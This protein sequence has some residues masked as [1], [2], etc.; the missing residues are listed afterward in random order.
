MDIVAIL[1]LLIGFATIVLAMILKEVPFSAFNNPAAFVVIF[2]GTIASV[3][4]ATPA[5]EIKNIG[6][7][8][9]VVFGKTRF[10]KKTDAAKS[11]VEYS[12]IARKEGLLALE[13]HADAE[14]DLFMK[15]GLQLLMDGTE[16]EKIEEALS[17]DIAAMQQRHAG[18]AQIMS[19]AGS[20]APTLGVL[21]AV[22]GLIAALGDLSD[23][24]RLSHAISAAF[25]ATVL[26]IFTGYVMWNPMANR[27]KRKTQLEV[28]VKNMIMD[29][30][31]GISKGTAPQMLE[32]NLYAYLTVKERKAMGSNAKE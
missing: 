31:C 28:Q 6:N 13:S 9:A 30:V 32:E 1:G 20:Y 5:G 19:Q 17:Q 3:M 2:M 21:G 11:L 8:F 4:V 27:L 26:G 22:L 23:M 15:R 10:I 14:K 25:I 29:G 18:N 24:D 7:I 16:P 12:K